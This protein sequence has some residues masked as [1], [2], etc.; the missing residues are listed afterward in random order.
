VAL[1][2]NSSQVHPIKPK[3]SLAYGTSEDYSSGCIGGDDEV[4]CRREVSHVMSWWCEMVLRWFPIVFPGLL[5]GG[6]SAYAI[7]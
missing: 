6:Q 1:S 3:A 4:Y 7:H 2:D 5:V